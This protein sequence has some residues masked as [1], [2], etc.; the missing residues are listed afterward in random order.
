MGN[1]ILAVVAHPDDEVLGLGGTLL[2]HVKDGDSVH[3]HIECIDG[4]R[5]KERRIAAALVVSEWMKTGLSFG[6]SPELGYV[7]PDLFGLPSADIVYTHF[8]GDLNRDH[9]LV[10]EAV[11]VAC[12]PPG[13]DIRYFETPSSTEWGQPFTPNLFVD[14]DEH[15]SRKAA[16]LARYADEMRPWPHPR[17]EQAIRDRARYWGSVSGFKAAEAFVIGRERW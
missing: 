17:S 8:P 9:R 3:V 14:I 11:Q 12:R 13:P 15:L 6:E 16:V 7:V 5:D 4:L 10:A 2:R 1:R